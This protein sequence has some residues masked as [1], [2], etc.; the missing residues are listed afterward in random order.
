MVVGDERIAENVST[1]VS[2]MNCFST[3]LYWSGSKEQLFKFVW[4]YLLCQFWNLLAG[5]FCYTDNGPVMYS[6]LST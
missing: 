3:V 1:C 4:L 5:N 6:L 2:S